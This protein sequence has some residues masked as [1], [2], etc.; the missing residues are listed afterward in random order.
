MNPRQRLWL[1]VCA[2]ALLALARD[3]PGLEALDQD[4]PI[5]D[6]L[7]LAPCSVCVLVGAGDGALAARLAEGGR[8]VVHVLD[9]DESAVAT[10]R[11]LLAGRGL[12]GFAAVEMWTGASLPYP[13]NLVNLVV[14]SRD[15]PDAELS[16]VL[17]P[18]GRLMISVPDLTVLCRLYLK[19]KSM[20]ERFQ[21]MR[22]IYGGQMDDWDFHKAG[23]DEE[24]LAYRLTGHR[25]TAIRRVQSFGLFDD[26]TT[27]KMFGMPIS[28]NLECRGPG[29]EAT[30]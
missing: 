29:Q 1:S 8:R 27:F 3:L 10:A 26:T 21:L 24:T 15:L 23:F 12:Q 9:S 14:S 4:P 11:R 5:D 7:R 19:R 25:F 22:V 16:R 28:L 2:A 18:G 20:A 13:E 6:V 17:A 30:G